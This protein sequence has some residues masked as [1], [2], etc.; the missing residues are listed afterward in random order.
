MLAV[1]TVRLTE[2]TQAELDAVLAYY[3]R[4]G[5]SAFAEVFEERL[6]AN[7]RKLA[8]FSRSPRSGVHRRE[9]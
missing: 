3:E 5:A 8:S 2:R 7:M 4:V 9:R 6:L 1:A